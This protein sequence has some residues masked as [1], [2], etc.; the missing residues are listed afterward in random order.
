MAPRPL[1]VRRPR[2]HRR[3]RARPGGRIYERTSQGVEHDWGE[4]VLWQPPHRLVYRWHLG[5]EPPES[6]EVSVSFT[7]EGDTTTVTMVHRG[8]ER[9]GAAGPE[10]RERNRLCWRGVIPHF[11]AACLHPS[12]GAPGSGAA[13]EDA[14]LR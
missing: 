11:R 2:P 3:L 7:G 9:L 12:R 14:Q 10:R 13:P 8:W 4:V 5:A 1:G 6:T